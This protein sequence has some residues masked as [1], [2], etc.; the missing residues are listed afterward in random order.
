[1]PFVQ[2]I[3]QQSLA[4]EQKRTAEAIASGR[5]EEVLK[6]PMRDGFESEIRVHRPK[7]SSKENGGGGDG[8]GSPLVVLLHGGGFFMGN[9]LQMGTTARTLTDLYAA[10]V[11]CISYRLAPEF[12][13]PYAH[14][15]GWDSLV[16]LAANANSLGADTTA[17]FVV[18]GASAGGN[19]AAVMAQKSLSD[20]NA[21]L[22]AP[23]TGLWTDVPMLFARPE[24]VPEEYKQHYL[25]AGQNANA[26][27]LLTQQAIR[28]IRD[29][30]KA[31]GSSPDFSPVNAEKPH[32]GLPRTFLQVAGMDMYRDDA[33]IYRRMLEEAGVQT[34][35]KVY[36]GVPHGHANLYPGL[37]AS[38]E[39]K[40]DTIEG[41]GWLL[42][43]DVG[44]ERV[45]QAMEVVASL[46]KD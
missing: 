37:R 33:L 18:G 30:V 28:F 32:V 13:W 9:N 2:A 10:T 20:N 46:K 22:A 29:S 27:G 26:P 35:L 11:A 31:D 43:R 40:I 17:G 23:L 36:V 8:D 44:R 24:N 6:I 19:I 3:R 5:N 1:L 4:A 7:P 21:K 25:S 45:V 14:H 38:K 16:W 15:D 12:P 41:I 42:G 39:A 34:R